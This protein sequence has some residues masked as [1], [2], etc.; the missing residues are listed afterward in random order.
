MAH[1]AKVL[2]EFLNHNYGSD[3]TLDGL[4]DKATLQVLMQMSE[5]QN[6]SIW[7]KLLD[8]PLPLMEFGRISTL[9]Y[10]R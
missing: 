6:R 1:R 8:N 4:I 7:E 5:K 2:Q 10:V 9:P 3:L